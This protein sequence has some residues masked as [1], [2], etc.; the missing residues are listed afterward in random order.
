MVGVCTLEKVCVCVFFCF[1]TPF[2]W[3]ALRQWSLTNCCCWG[4][5]S[6]A[7]LLPIYTRPMRRSISK[8]VRPE[9][10]KYN[11]VRINIYT[12]HSLYCIVY[13]IRYIMLLNFLKLLYKF[14]VS[15]INRAHIKFSLVDNNLSMFIFKHLYNSLFTCWIII[16]LKKI[17]IPFPLELDWILWISL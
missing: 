7:L 13:T 6:I 16:H 15:I 8:R 3:K 14:D 1:Q 2:Y 11:F 4:R 12:L 9:N 5:V 10:N 17:G